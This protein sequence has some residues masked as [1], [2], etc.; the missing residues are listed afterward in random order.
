MKE[1]YIQ[2]I[3]SI[4]LQHDTQAG[5]DDFLTAAESIL[6]D[7]FHW[8]REFSKQPSEATVV[9]MIHH[10]SR[11]ATEQDKVVALMTLAFVL[12]TTKMPADVAT[13]LFDELLFRFF[14]NCS[15]DE[16]LT[17]LKAMVANLYQLATEYSPF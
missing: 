10:L 2:A 15:S 5:D 8:V 13:G 11:A 1:Q 7:G 17:G 12:G 9:N 3:H 6:K 14:D 4:L 16:K